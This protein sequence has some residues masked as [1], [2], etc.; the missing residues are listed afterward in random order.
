MLLA[1]LQETALDTRPESGFI[2]VDPHPSTTLRPG[3]RGVAL[4][5]PPATMVSADVLWAKPATRS[6]LDHW[7]RWCDLRLKDE[8]PPDQRAYADE[9]VQRLLPCREP[10]AG[11]TLCV[12]PNRQYQL[13][14]PFSCRTRFCSS[15][16]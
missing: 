3:P 9:I 16:G 14:V 8:V 1:Q 10:D 6:F 5:I 4:T 15:C 7:D 11:Y 2:L 13:R 12:C